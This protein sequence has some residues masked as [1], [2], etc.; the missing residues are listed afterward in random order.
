MTV[1]GSPR[2]ENSAAGFR[3]A[4]VAGADALE[5]DTEITADGRVIVMHDDRLDRTTTCRG[6][7][8]GWTAAEIRA[9]CFLPDGA[10]APTT[11]LPPTLAEA[12]A[13]ADERLVS[14]ELEVNGG[15][16]LT[17]TTGADQL[18]DAVL[19]ELAALDVESR[20]LLSSFDRAAVRRA[21]A[22]DRGLYVG[23]LVG[24]VESADWQEPLAWSIA[25]GLDAFLPFLTISAEGLGAAR[26]AGLQT[27]VWTVNPE[28]T[29]RTLLAT[30][31]SGIITD[32]PGRLAA[33]RATRGSGGAS[34]SD[35]KLEF[36]TDQYRLRLTRPPVDCCARMATTRCRCH[37]WGLSTAWPQGRSPTLP[38]RFD[39]EAGEAGGVGESSIVGDE[40]IELGRD[41]ACRGEMDG[42]ERAQTDGFD[43]PRGIEQGIVEPKEMDASQ[44][45]SRR[46]H[47]DGPRDPH[48]PEHLGASEFARH[49]KGV[50]AQA[51]PQGV[52]LGFVDDKFHNGGRIEVEHRV[53]LSALR[54]VVGRER[55]TAAQPATRVG[56]AARD[57]AGLRLRR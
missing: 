39:R 37:G 8:S 18:T 16:C 57:Q 25:N 30:G 1:P 9:R 53:S 5:L 55:P 29:M 31:V 33:V 50:P 11:D 10:G 38:R 22:S 36:E 28:A 35:T 24:V 51:R 32:A 27:H 41:E 17:P 4:I 23:L 15:E 14:V 6:C 20:T 3:S 48:G 7:V 45:P 40:D 21:R 44:E 26:E 49:S 12:F 56:A 13:I 42:V 19:A 2:P 46:C 52:R 34:A 54:G 43:H 47:R